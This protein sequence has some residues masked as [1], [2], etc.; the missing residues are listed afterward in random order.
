M[1][2]IDKMGDALLDQTQPGEPAT[3][4]S[5]PSFIIAVQKHFV[6]EFPGKRL[7]VPDQITEFIVPR[8]LRAIQ[9]PFVGSKV[10]IRANFNANVLPGSCSKFQLQELD[11]N[12]D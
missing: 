3:V 1:F 7:T 6:A 10:S 8:E 11:S 12:H 9:G 4:L 5:L 2:A